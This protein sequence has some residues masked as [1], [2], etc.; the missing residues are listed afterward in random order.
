MSQIMS[1]RGEHVD[2]A[3]CW[4]AILQVESALLAV[5]GL[6]EKLGCK[7]LR[8]PPSAF[9]GP[10]ASKP[11]AMVGDRFAMRCYCDTIC[12]AYQ[13]PM[14]SPRPSNYFSFVWRPSS[15]KTAKSN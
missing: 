14:S 12:K 8:P 5:R 15:L 1:S 6:A 4:Q 7:E 9:G 3:C 11:Q 2:A 10:A 13:A